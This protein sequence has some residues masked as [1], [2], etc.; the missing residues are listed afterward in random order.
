MPF[1]SATLRV[2][3]P[4]ES[5]NI[6]KIG[7]SGSKSNPIEIS[8]SEPLGSPSNPI[9]IHHGNCDSRVHG[10]PVWPSPNADTEILWKS[11]IREGV[12][13]DVDPDSLNESLGL[14]LEAGT[15]TSNPGSDKVPVIDQL[16]SEAHLDGAGRKIV[17]SSQHEPN[18][19]EHHAENRPHPV[20]PNAV[21]EGH[22]VLPGYCNSGQSQIAQL[23][24]REFQ[25]EDTGCS[26]QTSW[27]DEDYPQPIEAGVPRPDQI[28]VI[29]LISVPCLDDPSLKK[30]DILREERSWVD[31]DESQ[32]VK[33]QPDIGLIEK[34]DLRYATPFASKPKNTEVF[35][36]TISE[37]R[38][39]NPQDK[40][41]LDTE[42]SA[43]KVDGNI[44][45]PESEDEDQQDASPIIREAGFI[46]KEH[47]KSSLKR[48]LGSS[49][50]ELPAGIRRSARVAKRVKI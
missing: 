22:T 41:Q 32:A 39:E 44:V 17:V 34:I 47:Q 35:E 29:D 24:Q 14:D 36:P 30:D 19:P 46:I 26:D 37:A 43:T 7:E 40:R 27:F 25:A 12:V 42:S 8:D 16:P 9:I 21:S 1:N 13:S 28:E 45:S 49:K 20:I 31:V 50:R 38:F 5:G 48:N 18:T 33:R 23:P 4:R 11:E 10:L 15:R 2:C 6:G 3:S